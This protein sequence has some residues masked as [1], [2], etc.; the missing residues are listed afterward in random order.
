MWVGL[1]RAWWFVGKFEQI[2][3]CS[4]TLAKFKKSL[5]IY[6]YNTKQMAYK[7]L[8]EQLGCI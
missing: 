2:C 6:K 1:R 7:A 4:K 3:S 5:G 8:Q